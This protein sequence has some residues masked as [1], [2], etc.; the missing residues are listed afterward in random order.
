MPKVKKG[1][2]SAAMAGPSIRHNPLGQVIQEDSD[3]NKYVSAAKKRRGGG[4]SQ[5]DDEVAASANDVLD[6]KSSRRILELSRAQQLEVEAE[7]EVQEASSRRKHKKQQQQQAHAA[8]AATLDSDDE[9]DNEEE[10]EESALIDDVGDNDFDDNDYIEHDADRGYVTVVDG[11]PGLSAEDE[12]LVASMMNTS[13]DPT[14]PNHQRRTLA[15]IILEKIEEKEAEKRGELQQAGD[16][17]VVDMLPPKVVQVYTDIGKILSRYTSGKLPK[18]F[19]VIPSLSNWEEVLYLTRPDLWTPQATYQATRIFASN[20]NPRMAQRYYN[21]VLLDAVRNDICIN[22]HLNY[23][24]Y[25]S[26]KKAVYKPA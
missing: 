25:M 21:L 26:L 14:N 8:A 16:D 1:I 13:N 17:G 19:K 2:R 4:N 22:K 6:E 10:E 15:D 12:A 20:L 24:Y 11:T 9:E 18:A 23:H 7:D 5:E 3:R